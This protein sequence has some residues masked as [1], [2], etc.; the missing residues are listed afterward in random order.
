MSKSSS[1]RC[2]KMIGNMDKFLEDLVKAASS[3]YLFGIHY[4]VE[5][6]ILSNPE[7]YAET[8]VG[9]AKELRD[10]KEKHLY[11]L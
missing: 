3:M 4:T 8:S 9:D 6:T 7:W 1:K 11:L 2:G 10:F 5:K